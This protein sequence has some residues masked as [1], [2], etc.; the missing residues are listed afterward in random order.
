MAPFG[1]LMNGFFQLC[2]VDFSLLFRGGIDE[3]PQFAAAQFL[4]FESVHSHS[5]LS[6]VSSSMIS[7]C[8][9]IVTEEGSFS[10]SSPPYTVGGLQGK[11]VSPINS[12]SFVCPGV[13]PQCCFASNRGIIAAANCA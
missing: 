6:V 4:C 11:G 1:E 10:R 7:H 3:F 2:F 8:D 5:F 9:C 12:Q 13:L